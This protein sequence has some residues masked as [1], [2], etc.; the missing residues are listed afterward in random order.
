[1]AQ[2]PSREGTHEKDNVLISLPNMIR[3]N[4]LRTGGEVTDATR[5]GA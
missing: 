3:T 1:M 5:D 2:T 4:T